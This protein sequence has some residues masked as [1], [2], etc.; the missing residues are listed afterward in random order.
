MA[1]TSTLRLIAALA[2]LLA[3]RQAAALNILSPEDPIIAIDLDVSTG[4]D[5][6]DGQLADLLLD[7]DPATK[8]LNRG[9][10]NA[11]F[12][13]T[14]TTSSVLQS[15]VMSTANDAVGRDPAS[16]L[17]YGTN[18]A[19]ISTEAS[20]GRLEDWTLISSGEL[21]LPEGRLEVAS[22]VGFAN[23]TVYSS[24]KMVWPTMKDPNQN[25]TQLGDIGF[26]SSLDGTGSDILTVGDPIISIRDVEY[27]S[28]SRTGSGGGMQEATEAIDQNIGT[29]YL[30]FGKENSGF[31][32]TPSKGSY[33]VSSFQI[34]TANDIP[35]RDPSSWELYG[36]NDEITSEDN[37][38]GLEENWTLIDSGSLELPAERTTAGPIVSVN[39]TAGEFS[40]YRMV[41]PTLRDSAATNSMQIAEVAFFV[42]DPVTL[43][44]DRSTG[45]ATIRA[46]Q[47]LTFSG[48]TLSSN[49]SQILNPEG[50]ESVAVN[51]GDPGDAWLENQ[52]SNEAM[53][54]ES[55]TAGGD[56]NGITL[57]AGATYSLGNI[58]SISPSNYEDLVFN[59]LDADGKVI[60]D[61]VEFIGDDI[62]AGDYT[63]DG[64]INYLDWQ[65]FREG[66]GGDYYDQS[67]A[68]AY[69]GGDLD[70]DL[71]SDAYDFQKLVELAGGLSALLSNPASVP[72][73]SSL[74]IIAIGGVVAVFGARRRWQRGVVA[75]LV[76]GLSF[77]VVAGQAS[78]QSFSVVGG[79]PNFYPSITI[80][81]GQA[82]DQESQGPEKLFDD[83]YLD[84]GTNINTELF[85]LDYNDLEVE[86]DQ[87]AGDGVGPMTL[88]MDYGSSVS[89]NWF[90][91]AQRSGADPTADR[92]GQ[93]DFWF[94]NT[95]FGGVLPDSAPDATFKLEPTDERVTTSTLYPFTLSGTHS[96]RYVAVQLTASEIS[97]SRPTNNIGGHEFRLLSGPADI[98]LEI[99]RQTGEM[100]LSNDLAG[101]VG[102]EMRNITISSAEGGLSPEAFNG[103][104]GDSTFPLGNGT[105]NGWEV[106]GGSGDTRLVEAYWSGG[107][108][109]S[110][111]TSDIALGAGYNELLASEDV[112][113]QWMNSDGEVYDG[114]VVYKGIAHD[115]HFGDYNDDGTVDLGDYTVWRDNLGSSISLPNDPTP[116]V[117]DISDYNRWKSY[118]G[119][120]S[121]TLAASQAVPEPS[122]V[123]LLGSLAG[124]LA[125]VA[126]RQK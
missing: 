82:N 117:V 77:V 30:N 33:A 98:V 32:V 51:G 105:G 13:V 34:T 68:R 87:Y 16:Y 10:P 49:N 115:L 14:P 4:S 59:L 54:G 64:V 80:P 39:N 15:F 76:F 50:W 24:Y 120:V 100:T 29:K 74:A 7:D 119:T 106:G 20:N 107:S 109:F 86:L 41:F 31:I 40:S 121:G 57:Q 46:D 112:H 19:I 35:A 3:A 22:A 110:A 90:A 6:R 67:A 114:R 47:T 71:D 93:F 95:D 72:E 65:V 8:T 42:D 44:I 108:T 75:S 89:A 5:V 37:S 2:V 125:V 113:F 97:T 81:E 104:G 12:I 103:I 116:G 23:S 62:M 43:L 9:G 118:F 83:T 96:G 126:R 21:S 45:E 123:V 79:S 11:G 55:D 48:Y 63:G 99:D 84:E 111:G 28:E 66:Y 91:Y 58:W 73:P 61:G 69:L 94:S 26:Y 92:V 70:G 102:I 122:S 85:L 101:A 18:D 27:T 60:G 78:A 53:L 88:F 36:T 38:G 52:D 1:C 25:L 17:I 124:L 56:D